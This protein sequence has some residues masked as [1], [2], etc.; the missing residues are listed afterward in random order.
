MTTYSTVPG[1]DRCECSD[2]GCEHPCEPGRHTNQ[3]TSKAT[4]T[5]WRVDMEDVS[6]TRFCDDCASDAM[7]AGIFTDEPDEDEDE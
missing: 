7:D 3:C 4:C 1:D 6:G 5:L 2:P